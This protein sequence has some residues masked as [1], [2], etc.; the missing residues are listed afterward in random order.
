MAET[1]NKYEAIAPQILEL[2]GGQ[3]NI[4]SFAHC[5]TCLLY[6]SSRP[7][8]EMLLTWGSLAMPARSC[9]ARSLTLARKLVSMRSTTTLAPAQDVYK[10]QVL[11]GLAPAGLQLGRVH[12]IAQ[13]AQLVNTH[14]KAGAGAGGRL[15]EQ[16]SLIHI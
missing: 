11:E 8:P 14:L 12:V 5:M 4:R 10:R 3:D 9:T 16:L 1:I 7:M 13:A 15:G 6:T 2:V